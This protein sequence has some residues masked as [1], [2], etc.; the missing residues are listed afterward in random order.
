MQ[1]TIAL[2]CQLKA[3]KKDDKGDSDREQ[4]FECDGAAAIQTDSFAPH[5]RFS[6]IKAYAEPRKKKGAIGTSDLRPA[7]NR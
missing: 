1:S 4:G 6:K 7:E 5:D 3:D 2:A